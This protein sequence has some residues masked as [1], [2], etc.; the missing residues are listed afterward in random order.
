M[1]GLPEAVRSGSWRGETAILDS[2]GREIP[3][4]QV[5]LAHKSTDGAVEYFSTTIRDISESKATELALRISENKF[6][7]QCHVLF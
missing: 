1:R 5:I 2:K 6:L 3:V 4:S 7:G